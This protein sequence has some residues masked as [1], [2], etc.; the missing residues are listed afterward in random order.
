MGRA[1]GGS[2]FFLTAVTAKAKRRPIKG[3]AGALCME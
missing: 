1:M 2:R 3:K